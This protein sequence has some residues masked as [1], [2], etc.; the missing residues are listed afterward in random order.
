MTKTIRDRSRE[1]LRALSLDPDEE[2]HRRSWLSTESKFRGG[3]REGG[4]AGW[5]YTRWRRWRKLLS[6]IYRSCAAVSRVQ[7]TR[8]LNSFLV[9]SWVMHINQCAGKMHLSSCLSLAYFFSLTVGRDDLR[10]AYS[11]IRHSGAVRRPGDWTHCSRELDQPRHFNLLRCDISFMICK[12]C[13]PQL[14]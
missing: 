8:L 7:V 4:R 5:S 3:K 6:L 14:K 2:G 13:C 1:T 12:F 11:F 9:R 10:L